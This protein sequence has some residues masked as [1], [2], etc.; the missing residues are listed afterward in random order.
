MASPSLYAAL[1]F[2]D[3]PRK[4]SHGLLLCPGLLC[5]VNHIGENTYVL[6]P[7]VLKGVEEARSRGRKPDELESVVSTSFPNHLGP[8]LHKGAKV[9]DYGGHM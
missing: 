1:M 9:G 3:W 5:L 4:E 6:F 7:A 2:E 8:C